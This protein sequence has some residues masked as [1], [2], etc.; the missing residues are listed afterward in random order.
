MKISQFNNKLRKA[1]RIV[2]E[3]EKKYVSAAKKDVGRLKTKQYSSIAQ[4]RVPKALHSLYGLP[5]RNKSR[6]KF[7]QQQFLTRLK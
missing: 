7:E 6:S 3:M 1:G 5:M 2:S 4:R